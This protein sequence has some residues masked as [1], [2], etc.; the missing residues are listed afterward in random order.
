MSNIN[1]ESLFE[2]AENDPLWLKAGRLA[3]APPRPT[4]RLRHGSVAVAGAGAA[5]DSHTRSSW[6]WRCCFIGNASCDGATL[7]LCLTTSSGNLASAARPST[8]LW[9]G[10]RRP[11]R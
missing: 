7:S 9:V 6:S 2:D 8:G 5:G 1:I 10:Y 11:E 3:D 4:K